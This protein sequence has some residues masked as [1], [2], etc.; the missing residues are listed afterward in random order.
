MQVSP[1]PNFPIQPNRHTA[2]QGSPTICYKQP[3]LQMQAVHYSFTRPG[4]KFHRIQTSDGPNIVP[5][6][7]SIVSPKEPTLQMHGIYVCDNTQQLINF[8]CCNGVP[9]CLH[10]VQSHQQRLLLRWN[11]LASE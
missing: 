4:A 8:L 1:Y 10:L 3:P 2:Y 11:E 9:S 7:A 5:H 6:N